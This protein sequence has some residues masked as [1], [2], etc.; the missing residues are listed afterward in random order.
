LE[1]GLGPVSI[2]WNAQRE[3]SAAQ[4]RFKQFVLEAAHPDSIRAGAQNGR[5]D[6]LWAAGSV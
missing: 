1:E 6:Q 4:S 5:D 3:C 2:V